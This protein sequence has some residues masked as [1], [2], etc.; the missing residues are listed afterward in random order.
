MKKHSQY[1]ADKLEQDYEKEQK[2]LSQEPKEEGGQSSPKESHTVA[3]QNVETHTPKTP[4]STDKAFEKTFKQIAER[5]HSL[6]STSGSYSLNASL[7]QQHL[8]T[9]HSKLQSSLHHHSHHQHEETPLMTP[10]PVNFKMVEKLVDEVCGRLE[11]HEMTFSQCH[12]LLGGRDRNYPLVSHIINI[13]KAKRQLEQDLKEKDQQKNK[14]ADHISKLENRCRNQTTEI[15]HL[16]EEIKKLKEEIEK[17]EAINSEREEK[18]KIIDELR[19][20]VMDADTTKKSKLRSSYLALHYDSNS[21]EIKQLRAEVRNLKI[22]NENLKTENLMLK[23]SENLK[24]L[25]KLREDQTNAK[26]EVANGPVSIFDEPQVSI[27]KSKQWQQNSATSSSL[28]SRGRKGD[29]D[30]GMFMP[31]PSAERQAMRGSLDN[32]HIMDSEERSR[33]SRSSR[34][35]DRDYHDLNFTFAHSQNGTVGQKRTQSKDRSKRVT[36]LSDMADHYSNADNAVRIPPGQDGSNDQTASDNKEIND[37]SISSVAANVKNEGKSER[38]G[39]A[40]TRHNLKSKA[41]S[42]RSASLNSISSSREIMK[43][44]SHLIQKSRKLRQPTGS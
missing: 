11:E 12:A 1:L 44:S 34:D 14:Y 17:L 9:M 18:Q 8:N 5:R 2:H 3:H 41:Q 10:E 36:F 35:K 29:I 19:K 4:G 27:T 26:A 39:R 43:M 42:K 30:R 25:A 20:M 21:S 28:Q 24:K 40:K 15:N 6:S 32:I 16:N 38:S 7:V 23:K 33:T 31:P 22:D 37:N 13:Q